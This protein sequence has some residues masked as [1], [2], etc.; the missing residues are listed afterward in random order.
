[1]FAVIT[2]LLLLS[3]ILQ[4]TF[5]N[6]SNDIKTPIKPG[7]KPAIFGNPYGYQPTVILQV[8]PQQE[9]N[10]HLHQRHHLQ[11]IHHLIHQIKGPPE[12]NP[13]L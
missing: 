11:Y 10:R 2:V 13:K 9:E 1:M 12:R 7:R 8:H 5:I 4:I 3:I 6:I